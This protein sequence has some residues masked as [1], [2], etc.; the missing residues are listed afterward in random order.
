MTPTVH[1][2]TRH[3]QALDAAHHIHPF[4]DTAALNREGV[5]ISFDLDGGLNNGWFLLRLSVH[6]P[7]MPLNVESDVAGGVQQILHELI[8]ALEE[9]EGVDLQPL[10]DALASPEN[11]Q[12]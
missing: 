9:A 11:Q 2:Q 4:S 7:V 12:A 1:N 3:W 6:D 5:R 8:K 10:R